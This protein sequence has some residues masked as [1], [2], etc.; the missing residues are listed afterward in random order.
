MYQ[1]TMPVLV[2][3]TTTCARLME[4]LKWTRD[5]TAAGGW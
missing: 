2:P 5:V 3:T 1:A 4:V